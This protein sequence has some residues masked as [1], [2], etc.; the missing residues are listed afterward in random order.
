MKVVTTE[1]CMRYILHREGTV[2]GTC[3]KAMKYCSCGPRLSVI[4]SDA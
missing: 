4:G 1:P 3:V 2:E